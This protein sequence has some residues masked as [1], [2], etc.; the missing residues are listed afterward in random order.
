[1]RP[2]R[3]RDAAHGDDAR[4]SRRP[5]RVA[6]RRRRRSTGGRRPNRRRS[7]RVG[8]RRR[9]V[10]CGVSELD[11]RRRD[12]VHPEAEGE[13][14]RPRAGR[15]VEDEVV[16][17]GG[18]EH[19]ADDRRR[20]R[21][22]AAYGLMSTG[23]PGVAD[24]PVL[25][26][27][28]D[29]PRRDAHAGRPA[30][31]DGAEVRDRLRDL[32]P[33][34]LLGP[35]EVERDRRGEA[36]F[37]VPVRRDERRLARRCCPGTRP[38]RVEGRVRLAGRA[39][40][41]RRGT[42]TGTRRTSVPRV[43][44]T[45]PVAS[46]SAA[47]AATVSVTATLEPAAT[48]GRRRRERRAGRRLDCGTID[49]VHGAGPP[50]ASVT[51]SCCVA[52]SPRL[53]RP[54]E[55]P[56]G[57]VKI[58]GLSARGMSIRPPPSRSGGH[59]VAGSRDVDRVAGR[60]ERRLDLL[61]RPRRVA[62]LEQ[63]GGA[64]DVRRRHARA[65]PV[66]R[67][68]LVARERREDVDAGRGDVRLHLERDGRRPARGEVRDLVRRPVS[69]SVEAATVIA[70]GRGARRSDRAAAG[71]G[72]VVAGRDHGHDSRVGR[73]VDRLHDDVAR[74]LDLRLAERE[75]D[76]VHAVLHGLLDAGGDLRASCRRARTARSGSSAPCS[77]RGTRSARSRRP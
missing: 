73:V 38:G 42:S 2:R 7:P 19:R 28:D 14:A 8:S 26:A 60:L 57:S 29:E 53:T 58:S 27:G 10:R 15:R 50:P 69:P 59:L 13:P 35:G 67:G 72:V 46:P 17:T 43:S 65:A 41:P 51:A 44:T 56:V 66:V 45:K 48:V 61:D 23:Q 6:R 9:R 21:R 55:S 39:A 18:G 68:P 1:M 24:E 62:L 12:V 71:V 32:D 34:D 4:R 25:V 37:R 30:E 76:H 22:S 54:N 11:G 31:D 5:R 52:V 49:T 20:R 40:A 74:R 36:A 63:R 70:F 47:S 33:E 3:E 75:V 77:C 16:R 64:G